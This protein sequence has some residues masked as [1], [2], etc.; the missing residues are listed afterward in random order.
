ML[1]YSLTSVRWYIARFSGVMFETGIF[2]SCLIFFSS[3]A[4]FAGPL[5]DWGS[6][7]DASEKINTIAMN[8]RNRAFM[9]SPH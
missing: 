6:A 5:D 1:A 8:S 9:A 4:S 3:S 7:K 2:S